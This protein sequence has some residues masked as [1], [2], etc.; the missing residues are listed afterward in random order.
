MLL[1][2]CNRYVKKVSWQSSLTERSVKP[3][4]AQC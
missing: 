1:R 3:L 4:I 2:D